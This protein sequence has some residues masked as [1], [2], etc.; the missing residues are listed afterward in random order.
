M[1]QQKSAPP[2]YS[3]A[4]VRRDKYSLW[5]FT[6]VDGQVR[7]LDGF[8]QQTAPKLQWSE[9][10]S[11]HAACREGN[12]VLVTSAGNGGHDS[13]QAFEV[14]DR[15]PVA[16]SEKLEVNGSVTALWTEQTGDEGA[17]AVVRNNETGNYEAALLNLSCS[18]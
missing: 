1:G 6:G 12:Q 13:I 14:A 15:E 17:V 11:V 9:I 3:S 7:M 4:E 8:N 18:H 2:F 10:A 16:V 5:V